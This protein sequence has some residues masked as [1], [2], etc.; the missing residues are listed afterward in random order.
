MEIVDYAQYVTRRWLIEENG[1]EYIIN[2]SENDTHDDW[3][4]MNN[5]GCELDIES[6]VAKKLIEFCE[7]SL[8]EE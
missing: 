3:Q 1:E 6:V 7:E 4:V 2:F 5:D 8:E